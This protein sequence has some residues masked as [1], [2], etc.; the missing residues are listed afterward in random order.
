MIGR[1]VRA[2]RLVLPTTWIVVAIIFGW[3]A[4]ESSR[5]LLPWWFQVDLTELVHHLAE[6][7]DFLV[8][9]V[10]AAYGMA[11]ATSRNPYYRDGYRKWLESTPWTSALPLPIGPVQL[12][13]QDAVVLSV[14]ATGMYDTSWSRWYVLSVFAFAY[15]LPI[16]NHLLALDAWRHA[17]AIG[18]LIGLGILLHPWLPGRLAVIVMAIL[19]ARHG[20]SEVLAKFPWGL[21]DRMPRL[22]QQLRWSLSGQGLVATHGWP[23][24][25]LAPAVL[26]SLQF[27]FRDG[28]LSSVLAGWIVFAMMFHMPREVA[29]GFGSML[30]VCIL[31]IP[32]V[33]LLRYVAW[34]G[35]PQSRLGMIWRFRPI[36]P[37]YDYVFIAPLAALASSLGLAWLTWQFAIPLVIAYP[38]ALLTSLLITLN[39]PPSYANWALTGDHWI[40]PGARNA[41]VKAI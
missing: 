25:V 21:E 8:I 5:W 10:A 4:I 23:H 32:A 7:R 36:A 15:S 30:G 22:W 3:C 39:A 38:I 27:N 16:A 12:V 31:T 40:K 24:G 9:Q 17:Y 6:M 35:Q 14:L 18:F 11:R 1:L 34:H 41:N 20:M 26:N 33:R 2:F 37:G 13:W 28:V 29:T 19:I